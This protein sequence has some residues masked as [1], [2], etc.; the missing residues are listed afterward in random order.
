[1]SLSVFLLLT[2]TQDFL[3]FRYKMQRREELNGNI[4]IGSQ[5]RQKGAL[6]FWI[7]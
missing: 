7:P 2:I 6:Y 1:M 4:I 5:E 3:N